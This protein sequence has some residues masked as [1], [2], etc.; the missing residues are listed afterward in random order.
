[1][2]LTIGTMQTFAL[3]STDEHAEVRR[4]PLGQGSFRASV[5]GRGVA[6]ETEEGRRSQSC[7]PAILGGKPMKS[8]KTFV[9]FV[10]I[11][12]VAGD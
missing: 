7:L 9:S 1:M 8:R 2:R 10:A 11:Q 4:T 5:L 3:T 6:I 12:L